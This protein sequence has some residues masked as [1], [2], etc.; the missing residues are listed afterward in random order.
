V[1]C[2][3]SGP[4]APTQPEYCDDTEY[5][6]G[7]GGQLSYELELKADETRTVWFG[8]GGSTSGTG[9]ARAELRRAL[10]DPEGHWP[11]SS[12]ANPDRQPDRRRPAR[13]PLL[14]DSVRWSK[15]MLAASDQKVNDLKLRWVEAGKRY[16]P[17]RRS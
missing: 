15:Q 10:D 17:P 7:V 4:N 14:E 3:A 5:G 11:T 8:V 16:P 13:Q 1:I 9:K 6:Q 2:P 12:P